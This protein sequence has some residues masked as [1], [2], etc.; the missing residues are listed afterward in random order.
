M[1]FDRTL[2]PVFYLEY[3]L[4]KKLDFPKND[5]QVI[6]LFKLLYGEHLSRFH[7]DTYCPECKK[8]STFNQIVI[9]PDDLQI[10]LQK[11]STFYDR[12]TIEKWFEK[13]PFIPI[14]LSCSRNSNHTIFFAFH[15]EIEEETVFCTKVGQYPSS[16]DIAVD[17][18]ERYRKPLGKQHFQ[19]FRKAIGLNAH[20]VGSGALIYLRRIIENKFIKDAEEKA[21]KLDSNWNEA[22]YES[23]RAEEKIKH[24]EPYISKY[25][26][27]NK[28]V[29]GI[30]SMGLHDLSE[31]E[32]LEYF[33]T[34]RSVIKL[35][36][37][38]IIRQQEEEEKKLVS[39]Q[40]NKI[41]QERK[42]K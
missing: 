7:L 19:E 17:E 31:E 14:H 2:I 21:Q 35:T 29:Y 27:E 13:T 32:C 41:H 38:E 20:G 10:E 16:A 40:L 18:L 26:V 4:Y 30:V 15:I 25:L 9:I 3:P 12:A 23:L 39:T 11:K 5:E 24:L 8:E 22:H 37:N 36:L 34:L 6:I 1:S 33:P 42:K 28:K